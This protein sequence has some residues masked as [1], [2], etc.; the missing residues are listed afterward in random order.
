MALAPA[1][2]RTIVAPRSAVAPR[3]RVMARTVAVGR[4]SGGGVLAP[5]LAGPADPIGQ[6]ADAGAPA[7]TPLAHAS[8]MY[9]RMY[10]ARTLRIPRMR[11]H[12]GMR[13]RP[14]GVEGEGCGEI[15]HAQPARHRARVRVR[16]ETAGRDPRDIEASSPPPPPH[17]R[18]LRQHA[19]PGSPT[20]DPAPSSPRETAGALPP[21]SIARA[22]HDETA[23]VLPA[24]HRVVASETAGHGPRDITILAPPS[25]HRRG[26]TWPYVP[27]R[28][29]WGRPRTPSDGCRRGRD[30]NDAPAGRCVRPELRHAHARQRGC[31][32]RDIGC[33]TRVGRF[34]R[35]RRND[36]QRSPRPH[37]TARQRGP[38]P[39]NIARVRGT[40]TSLATGSPQIAQRAF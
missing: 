34:G 29:E 2:A 6:P 11:I 27:D 37:L 32:P 1:L 9:P 39:R 3:A 14:G 20:R 23:R 10:P 31:A 28:N 18:R 8:R 38:C 36:A 35:G 24:R 13:V 40:A 5:A 19:R 15:A 4:G 12:T 22:T 17:A 26:P 16:R 25:T 7:F 30:S 21:R 33:D